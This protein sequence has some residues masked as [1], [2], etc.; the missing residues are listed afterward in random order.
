MLAVIA[1]TP[2]SLPDPGPPPAGSKTLTRWNQFLGA[3]AAGETLPEAMKRF[4]IT[5]ADIETCVRSDPAQYEAWQN[6]RLSAVRRTWSALELEDV[7]ERIAGGMSIT[8]ALATVKGNTHAYSQFLRLV[9]Q[10]EAVHAQYKRALQARSFHVSEEIVG[11][12]DDNK[13][14]I[15]AGPKGDIPNM[16]AVN[17]SKLRVDTRARLMS[18]WNKKM[19][20]EKANDVQVNVQV[21]HAARL[22]EARQRATTKVVKKDPQQLRDAIDAAFAEVG[23]ETKP[24]EGTEWMDA[25]APVDTSW[26]E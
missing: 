26:L 25:P 20:G 7:F 4:L 8:D 16:A 14:D 22:E 15:I 12:A 5:R 17:R 23:S 10:D 19:F 2:R 13:N 1:Q 6:A 24:A 21:N 18:A 9:T 3:I 11:I